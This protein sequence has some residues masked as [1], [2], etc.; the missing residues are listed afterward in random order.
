MCILRFY[1]WCSWIFR[2]YGIRRRLWAFE[3]E[4]T[5]LYQNAVNRLPISAMSYPR[6]TGTSNGALFGESLWFKVV[7]GQWIH[8]GHCYSEQ[9]C[10]R[11]HR[12]SRIILFW[13][14]CWP[15]IVIY[16]YSRSNKMHFL[17]SVCY[18]LTASA[19]FERY[20]LIIRRRFIHSWYIL[21]I[22][23]RLAASGVPLQPW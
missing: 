4:T 11:G 23:C 6:R 17:F 22:L 16:Q 8:N 21:C 10:R 5:R 3:D 1:R 18:E 15:C 2:S 20:L 9:Y 14:F 13:M 7:D 12:D 19:G